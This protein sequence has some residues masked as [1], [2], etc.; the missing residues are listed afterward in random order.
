MTYD[1]FISQF[2]IL[3]NPPVKDGF[4]RHHIVP[5]SEQTEPDN[6]CIYLLPSQHLWAHVLYD[7]ENGTNTADWLLKLAHLDEV[8]SY[9][10]CIPFDDTFG[11]TRQRISESLK[12]EKHPN[13][14]KHHSEET[15]EKIRIGNLGNQNGLGVVHSEESKQKMS[16]KMMNRPDE[17]KRVLR[18]TKD[19]KLLAEYPSAHEAARQLGFSRGCISTCCS[20]K[21]RMKTYKGSIWKYAS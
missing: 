18:Y 16:E 20:G 15:K 12:G 13:Y 11:V 17:S 8:H 21:G 9:E 5:V 4:H 6:R 10:D 2:E 14:G 1:N 19:M 7:Q 3:D